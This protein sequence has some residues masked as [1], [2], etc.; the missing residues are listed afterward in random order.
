VRDE[1]ADTEAV[2]EDLGMPRGGF[3]VATIHR[4][5]NT[6]DPTRLR[7]IV[8]ALQQV[9]HPV[10]LLAHPRLRARAE[11]HG[12][13]LDGGSLTTRPPLAYPALVGAVGAARGVIT[14]SGGLQKEAFALRTPCT[15]VRTETEWVETVQLGWNVLVEPGAALRDAAS[16]PAPAPTDAAPY[17]AGHAAAAVLDALRG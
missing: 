14:D 15:T 5:E 12:L 4:A 3:S 8:E 10:V 17:G 16:R 2:L 7:A 1:L 9:D 11:E 6:D 13:D